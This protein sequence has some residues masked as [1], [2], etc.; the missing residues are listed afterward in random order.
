M[1]AFWPRTVGVFPKAIVFIAVS[2][3]LTV[4]APAADSSTISLLD[5]SLTGAFEHLLDRDR[6]SQAARA[7][8]ALAL[9]TTES[10]DWRYSRIDDLDVAAIAVSVRP[11][12]GSAPDPLAAVV[13]RAATVQIV[14]GY[15]TLVTLDA[16]WAAKGLEVG[17][18]TSSGERAP[19]AA[20]DNPTKFDGLHL[21]LAPDALRIV[22][23][24]GLTVDAPVVVLNHHLVGETPTASFPHI[25]V[26]V[27]EGACLTVI[28]HQ[29]SSPPPAGRHTGVA[30]LSVPLVE[31]SVGAAARLS[32]AIVENQAEGLWQIGRQMSTVA[33]QATLTSSCASFGGEYN[34][35]RFDTRLSG[36]GAHGDLIAL[37]YGDGHQTHDFRTFQHH[38]DQDTTSDLLFKGAVDDQSSSVYTGLIHIHPE[39]R[40]SDARQTNR[41]IKLSDDAWAW[42]VPNLEIENSDVR[43]SHA[44]AVSPIDEDQR[45]YLHSRGVPPTVADRL[46]VTGFFDEVIGRMPAALH[47][48]I[49][50]LV[51]AKLDRR[52]GVVG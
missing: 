3:D 42:S 6:R 7:A 40:G 10:E 31:L 14:N 15:V 21:A 50:D 37:Y 48:A 26:D 1:V 51:A 5:D 22:V 18:S 41:N 19:I 34:R 29:S 28:E 20:A 11:I 9:P 52:I 13:N 44:S 4:G 39:G 36:R 45:F 23:P 47:D 8:Q 38:S 12:P 49:T 35:L 24:S 30:G 27:G 46:I 16:G 17:V 2:S 33:G 25:T 43:C 32:Y